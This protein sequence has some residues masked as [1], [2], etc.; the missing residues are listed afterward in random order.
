M[1]VLDSSPIIYLAKL[2]LL[3]RLAE[4]DKYYVTSSVFIEVVE[5]AKDSTESE[6]I[7]KRLE[8]RIKNPRTLISE[9]YGLSK[10]DTDSISLA[11]ELSCQLIVDEKKGRGFSS[12][13]SIDNH[14]TV[15]VLFQLLRKG[16]ITKTQFKEYLSRMVSEGFW[17]S[18]KVYEE[19]LKSV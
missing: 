4:I 7:R 17:L 15:Y 9:A 1:L 13:N 5:K 12:M 3:E 11:K 8:H 2:R 19:T 6:Y 14:G 18:I 16:V 10:A